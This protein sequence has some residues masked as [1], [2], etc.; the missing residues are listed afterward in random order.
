MDSLEKNQ[1]EEF[2][3]KYSDYY[4]SETS[5]YITFEETI[6]I[7]DIDESI[8]NVAPESKYID[9]TFFDNLQD[10]ELLEIN[11]VKK[12]KEI[13]G[14]SYTSNP[15]ELR[16]IT[17]VNKNVFLFELPY[18]NKY[19]YFQLQSFINQYPRLNWT[20]TNYK[21][22][23]FIINDKDVK[24]L[25]DFLSVQNLREKN[26]S[27]S[28][29]IPVYSKE[30]YIS[31]NNIYNSIYD[32]K[33]LSSYFEFP[34]TW[35]SDRNDVIDKILNDQMIVHFFDIICNKKLESCRYL[36]RGHKTIT[37][38]LNGS[39]MSDEVA[40]CT[41]ELFEFILDIDKHHD[42]LS[43]LRN[44]MTVFLDS[45]SSELNFYEKAD[46]ILKAVKYNFDLYIQ[47]KVKLF[48]DQK[49][50]LL[51]EFIITTKK[52]EDLTNSL[53]SQIRTVSLSLLGTIFLSLLNDLNKGKTH[54]MINLALLSYISYFSFN[55]V[56]VFNQK[57]QK[58][59]LIE[60]LE[61]Y[62]QSL[63]V[64]GNS[65][66]NS[67]SYETLKEDYLERS[68]NTFDSY[69][70]WTIVGL[71]GLIFIFTCLYISNRFHIFSILIDTLK[72]IIGY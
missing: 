5:N 12:L 61:K 66:N 17:K 63:G 18:K 11:S 1:V 42:K 67:L 47:D 56:I 71:S 55:L 30:R 38:D 50:K 57:N 33:K 65:Q 46:E 51:Q 52:I 10:E 36:I 72:F 58:E 8:I 4:C 15:T 13:N 59:S 28:E 6:K 54:A 70:H 7:Q 20:E 48:L 21:M 69:R 64:V 19:I 3:I 45:H 9:I 53:I 27:I 60:S 39:E 26:L 49:N 68:L 43:L 22:F 24:F 14:K 34:L 32:D 23:V 41:K 29:K 44:T 37:I 2:I 31:F 35:Y 40:I 16:I 62:T 25:S